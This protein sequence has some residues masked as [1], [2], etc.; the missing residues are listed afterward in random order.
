MSQV[1]PVSRRGFKRV[2][3]FEETVQG[4][5][6]VWIYEYVAIPLGFDPWSQALVWD[7]SLD[8]Y[9]V[10]SRVEW[11]HR[12]LRARELEFATRTEIGSIYN[13]IQSSMANPDASTWISFLVNPKQFES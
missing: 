12:R 5:E 9:D 2:L 13:F 10:I 3:L 4:F 11:H 7:E 1:K 6:P 8:E